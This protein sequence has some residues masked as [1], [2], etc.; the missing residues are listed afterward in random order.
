M[1]GFLLLLFI[2]VYVICLH[3]STQNHICSAY[4]VRT[5]HTLCST[6]KHPIWYSSSIN[7]KENSNPRRGISGERLWKLISF[8]CS[9]SLSYVS[10]LLLSLCKKLRIKLKGKLPRMHEAEDLEEQYANHSRNNAYMM[11]LLC[12]KPTQS[13][14]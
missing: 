7:K 1:W 13:L 14:V 3:I 12:S 8:T 2:P 11:A 4:M 6:Y 9:L 10:I 5:L